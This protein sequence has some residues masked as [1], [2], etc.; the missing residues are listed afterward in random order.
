MI[1]LGELIEGATSRVGLRS[2]ASCKRRAQ[3]LD[4]WVRFGPAGSTPGSGRPSV[5]VVAATVAAAV[6]GAVAGG[7]LG[8]KAGSAAGTRLRA[9]LQHRGARPERLDS[10]AGDAER[11]GEILG[12]IVGGTVAALA[13][14]SLTNRSGVAYQASACKYPRKCCGLVV[15]GRCT[16]GCTYRCHTFRVLLQT[17]ICGALGAAS[18]AVQCRFEHED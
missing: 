5:V 8:K 2:C 18:R 4:R 13:V 17:F 9:K 11:G 3:R 14:L 16:V 12:R 1:G 6:G 15:N 10:A 7:K